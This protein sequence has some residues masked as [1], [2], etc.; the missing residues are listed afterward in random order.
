MNWT[1]MYWSA[2]FVDAEAAAISSTAWTFK[3]RHVDIVMR[4]LHKRFESISSQSVNGGTG[5]KGG[6]PGGSRKG[7]AERDEE[8]ESA[9]TMGRLAL[10]VL[11]NMQLDIKNVH[12][13]FEDRLSNPE[14]PFAAG[15]FCRELSLFTT[16][17]NFKKVCGKF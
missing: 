9:G 15:I 13:R 11:D 7:R 12:V 8:W 16:N 3:Q 17:A 5:G 2:G 4:A 6:G 10:R 14:R 1:L